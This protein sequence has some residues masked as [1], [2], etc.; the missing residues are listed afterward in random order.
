MV[1]KIKLKNWVIFFLVLFILSIT[2]FV[3]KVIT[4]PII[5]SNFVITKLAVNSKEECFKKT[6]CITQTEPYDSIKDENVIEIGCEFGCSGIYFVKNPVERDSCRGNKYWKWDCT[7]GKCN[8]FLYEGVS[9]CYPDC[10]PQDDG[11]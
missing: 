8:C 3:Y 7:L 1:S 10:P 5:S 6:T 2:L 9:D 4:Y 11:Y